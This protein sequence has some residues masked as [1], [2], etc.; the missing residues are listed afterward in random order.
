MLKKL[1]ALDL[2]AYTRYQGVTLTTEGR[3]IA[4]RMVRYHRLAESYLADV[5]GMPWDEVHAEAEEWEHVL[6]ERVIGRMN[7]ALGNPATDP[8]GEPI[9]TDQG[10]VLERKEMTLSALSPGEAARISRVKA[11]DPELLR[12]VETFGIKPG[13]EITVLEVA[14]FD[15]PVTV[16]VGG[17]MHPIGRAVAKQ[18][19][20]L[21]QEG[22]Q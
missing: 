16:I 20:V 12:H 10:T 3:A 15:G 21:R 2:V 7:A 5:L 14:P 4:L 1:S 19:F 22:V 17:K 18:I 9:P 11:R 13:A 8:H 6:S